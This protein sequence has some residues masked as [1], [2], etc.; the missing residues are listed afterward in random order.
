M[1]KNVSTRHIEHSFSCAFYDENLNIFF[2]STTFALN[3]MSNTKR[4]IKLKFSKN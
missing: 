3:T 4:E 2:T 1:K